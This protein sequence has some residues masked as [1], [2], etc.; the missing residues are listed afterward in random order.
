M[1]ILLA[2]LFLTVSAWAHADACNSNEY[3]KSSEGKEKVESLLERSKTLILSKLEDLG[4]DE[5][6]ISLKI[7][8]T[9]I[10]SA[11]QSVLSIKIQSPGMV[12]D[13]SGAI[14]KK[15][16]RDGECGVE[17]TILGG[18]LLNKQNGKDFGSLGR[19]KEFVRLN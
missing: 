17:I 3:L 15:E 19:V 4:F 11:P 12:V 6:K 10:V 13:D 8:P 16:T 9:Q 2:F 7:N 18:R 5:R 1:K 14:L